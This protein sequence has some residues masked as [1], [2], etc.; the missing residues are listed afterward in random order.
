MKEL[1]FRLLELTAKGYRCSQIMFLLGLDERRRENTD[2][3]RSMAGFCMENGGEVCG[4]LSGAACFV[5]LH[6][7][8]GEDPETEDGRMAPMLR[9]LDDWFAE[10]TVRRY[11]GMACRQI[12]GEIPGH[13][14]MGRC[15]ELIIDTYRRM[16]EILVSNGFHP[17]G[18]FRDAMRAPGEK[19]MAAL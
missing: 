4:V 15:G 10:Y 11:D 3:V 9:E 12:R 7:G 2:L 19:R 17:S 5:T 18:Y 1:L 14:D 8:K 13:P 16:M 6:S